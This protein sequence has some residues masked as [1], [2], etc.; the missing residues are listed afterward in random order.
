MNP[1]TQARIDASLSKSEFPRKMGLSRTF[2]QR[3][4]AG[5]YSNPG[6]KLI[7]FT[8]EQLSISLK[9]FKKLYED[10]QHDTRNRTAELLEPLSI[11]ERVRADDFDDPNV[12][13]WF[14][15]GYEIIELSKPGPIN[16][17]SPVEPLSKLR[18][19]KKVKA[20]EI[21]REWRMSYFNATLSFAQ[22]FCVHLTSLQEYEKGTYK[23]M[24]TLIENAL[25]EVGLIDKSFITVSEWCYVY[26]ES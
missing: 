2:V 21:F 3:A 11:P 17:S 4:E 8:C 18:E 12:T 5:C 7:N 15:E 9:E 23:K 6:V 20:N 22:A 19:V 25:N 10:F 24:P 26:A 16:F 13:L 1:I 14:K